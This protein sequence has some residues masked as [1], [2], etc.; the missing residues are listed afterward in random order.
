MIQGLWDCKFDTS[1][2]VKLGDAD[3]DTYKYEPMNIFVCRWEKIKK[4]KHSKHC[5]NQQNHFFS[6]FISVDG[7]LGMEALVVISQLSRFMA[8]KME[9]PLFQVNGWVNGPIVID[10]AMSYSQMISGAQLPSP[11]RDRELDWDQ[12]SG[13]GLS[14]YVQMLK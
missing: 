14:G 5:Q 9:E 7:M 2:D 1:I 12:E 8:E 4:D 13:I 3:A 11:L 10:V 6:F